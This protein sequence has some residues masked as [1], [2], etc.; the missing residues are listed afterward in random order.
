MLYGLP[1]FALVLAVIVGGVLVAII[2][3]NPFDAYWALLRGMFGSPD[4]IASSI[5]RS[6]PYIGAA[7]AVAF[8]FKAGLFNIGVEGQLLVGGTLAAWVATWGFVNDTPGVIAIPLV[9]FAGWAGGLAYGAFPGWLKARTGARV[10]IGQS[11]SGL[12]IRTSQVLRSDD[13]EDDARVDL[14]ACRRHFVRSLVCRRERSFSTVSRSAPHVSVPP[15]LSSEVD[16]PSRRPRPTGDVDPRTINAGVNSWQA[17][18]DLV[19]GRWFTLGQGK[20]RPWARFAQR[21]L[22]HLSLNA[23]SCC[24]LLGAMKRHSARM[25][26][27]VLL[28]VMSGTR[29]NGSMPSPSS[30]AN[31][32][33]SPHSD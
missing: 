31:L 1:V 22:K 14:E 8:A 6:T 20:G 29:W 12:S 4:R 23:Q 11:L 26:H 17:D 5:S 19:G 28:P 18:F 2:G 27:S 33:S 32:P 25:P 15:H 24:A 3:G 30:S 16:A 7:L 13:T 10:A 9:L 21:L